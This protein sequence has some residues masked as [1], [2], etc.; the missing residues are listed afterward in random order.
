MNLKGA[1]KAA[2]AVLAL[3]VISVG[4]Y[5][6]ASASSFNSGD[7]VLAMFNNGT[8]YVDDLGQES[9]LLAGPGPKVITVANSTTVSQ[10]GGSNP[11]RWALI[12]DS[13]LDT[14]NL[15]ATSPTP[16]SQ[17]S[18]PS[19]NVANSANQAIAWLAELNADNA[20]SSYTTP[21]SSGPSS[22]APFQSYSN[23]F[24]S[25]PNQ[26]GGGFPVAM[27][28]LLGNTMNVLSGDY[29]TNA[30]TLLGS[31]T[32]SS[33]GTTLTLAPLATPVP[34]AFVLFVTGVVGIIG[35][36]RRQILSA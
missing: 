35:V 10:V 4:S 30:L 12:G 5:G 28:A 9:T 34:A 7:L 1:Q 18:I 19:T 6:R 23:A 11:V 16:P 3:G 31:A 27:S 36:A 24:N 15:F 2:V 26:L 8:E 20:P 21:A 17:I 22:G 33:D 25:S 13:Y 14:A 29:N 32:L